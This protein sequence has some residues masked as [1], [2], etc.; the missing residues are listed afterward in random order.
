M[1]TGR[2]ATERSTVAYQWDVL[3]DDVRIHWEFVPLVGVGPVRFDMACEQVTAA[4]ED[5]FPHVSTRRVCDDRR[6]VTSVT[7][8]PG[9]RWG[10]AF[11]AYF[12]DGGLAGV[13][14]HARLGPQVSLYGMDL[15]C[16]VPSEVEDEFFEKSDMHGYD[17]QY[18]PQVDV[19]SPTLGVVLRAERAG[20]HA[21]SRPVFVA[22]R[23]ADMCADS[24]EG[25]IPQEEWRTFLS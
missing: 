22:E 18:G 5:V 17:V 9:S 8:R 10:G 4:V 7:L 19:G 13:A 25:R 16:R 11:T 3:A 20:D 12:D 6:E 2:T 14:V 23:W 1:G 15:V 24:V 21:R